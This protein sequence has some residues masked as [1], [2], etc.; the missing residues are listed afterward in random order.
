MHK[1]TIENNSLI[2][3]LNH[4][5][6]DIKNL[7]SENDLLAIKLQKHELLTKDVRS[8]QIGES[9]HARDVLFV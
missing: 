8:T 1:K 4:L 5:R 6:T 3:R 7:K 9:D 2:Y